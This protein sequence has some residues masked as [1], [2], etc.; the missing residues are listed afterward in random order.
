MSSE[1]E[2]SLDS[3]RFVACQLT[4]GDVSTSLDM[5]DDTTNKKMK[6]LKYLPGVVSL[7]K[8]PFEVFI[9]EC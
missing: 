7:A 1:V 4:L 6:N 5:T 2:K 3:F 8:F 9:H